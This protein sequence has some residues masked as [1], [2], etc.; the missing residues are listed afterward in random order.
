MSM[1]GAKFCVRSRAAFAPIDG[2]G[3]GSLSM[4]V[5]RPAAERGHGPI[6][7]EP[8]L[9]Q[10]DAEEGKR[11]DTQNGFVFGERLFEQS[12]KAN[13]IRFFAEET[14]FPGIGNVRASKLVERFGAGL[15]AA[16]SNRDAGMYEI[17]PEHTANVLFENFAE[18][19]A[20]AELA[21]YLDTLGV[22]R[23]L[24]RKVVKAWGQ[25][26][27]EKLRENPYLLISWVP[28]GKVDQIGKRVGVAAEDPMRL[29]AACEHVLYTRLGQ[30]H[31]WTSLTE[32]KARLN[33]LI[34]QKLAQSAID[35]C[36]E[37]NGAVLNGDGLQPL[38]AAIMERF[39]VRQARAREPEQEDLFAGVLLS[40]AEFTRLLGEIQD[41]QGFSFTDMQLRAIR[42]VLEHRFNNF[43][44]YAGSGKTSV[45]K[46]VCALAEACGLKI[47]LMALSGR[48]AKRITEATGYQSCTI[49]RFTRDHRG[50]ELEHANLILVDE[51]SMVDLPDLYRLLRIGVNARVCLVGDPAQ[52][53]PIGFGAPFADLVEYPGVNKVVLDKVHRQ[54]ETTGI[55]TIAKNIRNGV[56]DL[57]KDYSGLEDGV[58]YLFA[59][60][61]DAPD[62]IYAIGKTFAKAGCDRDDMQIIAPVK[63]G[64]GGVNNLNS[65]MSSL[66]PSRE[67]MIGSSSIRVGDPIVYLRNDQQKDLRNGSLGRL[68]G[69]DLA[70]FEGNEVGIEE[71]DV[72]NIDL[73]YC[74]TVHKSQ[75]SQWDR[76]IVPLFNSGRN[77]FVERSLIYTAVTRAAKQVV[78][79]GDYEAYEHAVR[80]VTAANKRQSGITAY[81]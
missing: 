47:H 25:L 17:I 43:A 48:A 13:I 5:A 52:L 29:C 68:I 35:A 2:N 11:T 77:S 60:E 26:G 51:A 15:L 76:V 45:L 81:E 34:G 1:P 65:F 30:G 80:S 56:P 8:G 32:A 74:L 49:A 71:A 69:P 20:G 50:S 3:A 28:W 67:F 7:D 10:L 79:V 72:N 41:E 22:D 73:A 38:G 66:K 33:D 6:D 53:P 62:Q 14:M 39:V 59:R 36:I 18:A 21:M 55:P 9:F 57:L 27:A 16:I 31:T 46:A 19:A 40:E 78:I 23:W 63:R 24:G 64:N 70:D 4:G 61:E 12:D 58:Q 42:S 75:G 37:D 54:D 44:G